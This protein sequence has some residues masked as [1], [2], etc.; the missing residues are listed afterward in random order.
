MFTPEQ[1]HY[2]NTV[3]QAFKLAVYDFTEVCNE[4]STLDPQDGDFHEIGSQDC[5]HTLVKWWGRYENTYGVHKVIIRPGCHTLA[6]GDP[7]YPEEEGYTE[8]IEP[9]PD[10]EEALKALVRCEFLA[11]LDNYF[12]R[13]KEANNGN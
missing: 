7:G 4:W 12:Q 2:V 5:E 3:V 13:M 10:I 9:T 1:I 6:N 8:M 11:Q